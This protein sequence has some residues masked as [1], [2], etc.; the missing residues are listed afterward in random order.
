MV[1]L[2]DSR[3]LDSRVV[4]TAVR[5]IHLLERLLALP[6]LV[7]AVVGALKFLVIQLVVLVVLA[8]SSFAT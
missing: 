2:T 8:W 7:A 3:V 5:K 4:G 1:G 6:I